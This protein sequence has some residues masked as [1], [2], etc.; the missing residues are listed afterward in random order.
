MEGP[1][2]STNSQ[3]IT[4][5][6]ERVSRGEAGA[7]DE[8]I[9][10]AYLELHRI[11][12]QRLRRERPDHTL[13]PTALVNEVFLRLL[14]DKTKVSWQNRAHFFAA[15]SQ[16]MRHLLVD[17]ARHKN[18]GEHISVT[19][20]DVEGPEALGIVVQTDEN[21]VAL[22]EALTR[23]QEIDARAAHTVELRF[24]GGL[25]IQETAEV[26]NIDPATVKRD[27][28]FAKSSLYDQVA[29]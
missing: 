14:G 5:I 25:T 3:E 28:V 22:D 29:G 18:R 6:L 1:S 10:V 20:D 9:A 13:Q 17:H 23:L 19:I 26:L 2:I 15:M 12:A 11:A 7:T 24:F 4:L 16:K 21:L 27:W 8:L